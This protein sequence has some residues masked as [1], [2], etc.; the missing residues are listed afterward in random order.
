MVLFGENLATLMQAGWEVR[1]P[2]APQ[3]LLASYRTGL[4]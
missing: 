4:R 2:T 1:T 3:C